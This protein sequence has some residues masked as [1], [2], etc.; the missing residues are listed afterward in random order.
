MKRGGTVILAL[1]SFA[2][3]IQAANPTLP[4][5]PANAFNVTNYGALGNGAKDNTTNIQNAINAAVT[6]GGGTVEI[7]AAAAA[8]LSGPLTLFSSINLQV[9]T[10]AMLQMLPFGTF[11]TTV[12]NSDGNVY[13]FIFCKNV[14]DLEICGG[15]TIDGQGAAWW[16][17]LATNNSELPAP[18]NNQPNPPLLLD[19]FSCDRLFIHDITFQNSPY[20]HCGIRDSGGNITI[21][22]LT[23]SAPSTSPNTD[24]IDFVGTNCLIE[25][26][27]ISVGDD[28]IA[29]GSTGPLND[30]VISNCAFG[31]GH[32]VSIGSTV[33]DGIT[34]L[35]VINCS[36]NGT[37]NGIRMKCDPD[38][39]SPVTNLNYLNISMTNVQLPI[40]IYTYYSVTGTPNNI[41]T[42]EVLDQPAEPV[43]STTPKW[44]GITISNLNIVSGAGSDI[45]G[46]IWGPAEWPISNL[47]LVCITNNAPK[48]FDLYNVYGVQIINSQFNF[49]S[50]NTFT[51]CNAGVTISNSVPAGAVETISGAISANSLA[52]YNAAA[53]M[54]STN[55]FAAN[56]VT[57]SGGVLTNTSNL[58]LPASTTQNFSLGT[59]SSTIAVTGNLTLNSTLNISN[60]GGFTATN[61]TLFTYSGSLS[62]QPVLGAMPAGFEDYTFS[63]NTNI[64]GHVMLVVA[65][66]PSPSFDNAIF[67][68]SN[69]SLILS[70]TGGAANGVYHVLTSTNIAL[71][72]NAWTSV[73]TNQFSAGG[74][75]TFTNSAATNVA[76]RFFRLQ[77]P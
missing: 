50:G 29:L 12:T 74:N 59:N 9:D 16:N 57:I 32:G 39:S 68:G 43:N 38:A 63:I 46:I 30:L 62:G 13:T 45:G 15:G 40:V 20:H 72:L 65:S 3:W 55:L 61:Y 19:L 76:Q 51:L 66:P 33:T 24:G 64:V 26:C 27:Q 7:P 48:T 36:F 23:E 28:N 35:T 17:A 52:L 58:T 4:T 25:N 22:N 14:H 71:P 18:Y 49:S 73:A 2:G 77:L 60:A 6:A 41:S 10:G 34:N 67:A 11:P 37:V 1:L 5:I 56:P 75:F 42:A 21:S 53:S 44:D 31:S 8:Y 70:G 54:S 47:T 69:G